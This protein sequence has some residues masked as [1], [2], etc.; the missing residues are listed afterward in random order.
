[1]QNYEKKSVAPSQNPQK[2]PDVAGY[3][4]SIGLS[5]LASDTLGETLPKKYMMS[6]ITL[7][8]S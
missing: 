6:S 8:T 3:L 7:G 5:K 4:R 1:M 2:P